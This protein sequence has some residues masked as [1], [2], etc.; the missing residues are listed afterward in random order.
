MLD[1]D[2]PFHFALNTICSI[3]QLE[4]SPSSTLTPKIASTTKIELLLIS[5]LL[6]VTTSIK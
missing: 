4:F 1:V 3:N 5:Y 6:P 2:P